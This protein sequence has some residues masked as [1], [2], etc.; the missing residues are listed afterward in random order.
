MER[1]RE[2]NLQLNSDKCEFLR[3]E[4]CYLGHILSME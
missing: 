3:K 2:S 4:V 1:L